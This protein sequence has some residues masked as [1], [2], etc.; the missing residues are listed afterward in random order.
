MT[1]L[2]GVTIGP[3]AVVAAGAVVN[4][5]V[6]EGTIAGGVPAKAIG[7]IDK[8]KDKRYQYSKSMLNVKENRTAYLWKLHDYEGIHE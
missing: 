6:P 1:I 4:R 8:L 7:T 2:A 5:D 3:N